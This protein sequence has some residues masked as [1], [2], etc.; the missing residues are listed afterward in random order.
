MSAARLLAK[1]RIVDGHWLFDG[2]LMPTGYGRL[3]VGSLTDGSRRTVYV[4]RLAYELWVGPIPDGFDVHHLCG[5]RDCFNP[6]H[7]ELMGAREHHALHHDRPDV[8][9]NGHPRTPENTYTLPTGTRKCR[10]CQRA[11]EKRYRA[12]RHERQGSQ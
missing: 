9:K 5:R 11:S 7:L 8:C 2:Y 4:H 12:K 6:A 1:R 10:V 3:R